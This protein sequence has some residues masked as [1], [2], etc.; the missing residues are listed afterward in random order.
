MKNFLLL[1]G[2]LYT[3]LTFGQQGAADSDFDT[4]G[5][6]TLD[7]AYTTTGAA[8]AVQPDGKILTAGTSFDDNGRPNA[9][10]MR[11]LPDGSRD[12]SF[13]NY[14]F[15][16]DSIYAIYPAV[17]AMVLQP[18]GS[19]I[20][21]GQG[22]GE[23][24]VAH[25]SSSGVGL[26][27]GNLGG[28]AQTIFGDGSY[29]AAVALQPDGRII[30]AGQAKQNNARNFVVVRYF[31]DGL[32]DTTFSYDGKVVTDF[33]GADDGANAVVC[34]SDGKIIAAGHANN[35][36]ALVR[37]NPDGI[38]DNS[39]GTNG[40]V[41]QTIGTTSVIKAMVLQPNGQ[42]LVAGYSVNGDQSS[43][44][45]R[46][47]T[48][49]ALDNTFGTN[50]I[51][52][53][54]SGYFTS[55]ALQPDG[56]IVAVGSPT[57][58]QAFAVMRLLQ[59]GAFDPDF[60]Q[61]GQALY[62]V[63]GQANATALQA[64]GKIIVAGSFGNTLAVARYISSFSVGTIHPKHAISERLIYPNPVTAN[65]TFGFELE[66]PAELTISVLNSQGQLLQQPVSAIT[67]QSGKQEIPLTLGQLI[68]GTYQLVLQAG[69][70][71]VTT[72][73]VKN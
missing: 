60:G 16:I 17:N 30:A 38:L 19:I 59:N 49:G 15:T 41:V 13:G 73:F 22:Y 43:I 71:L 46:Y 4:D 12:L 70:H 55:I 11:L 44:I 24:V 21:A 2:I 10:L 3:T 23:P 51:F 68:P 35:N 5:L 61:A 64:D 37:Y 47:N 66:S 50:G 58:I 72:Q 34:Q 29:F 63:F 62:W 53:W 31:P 48:N 45:A 25:F 39:F 26:P 42:I 32:L 9:L 56:K 69:G 7:L 1:C 54:P 57:G 67:F 33:F 28:I 65:A 18:N 6:V 36:F 20:V 27:F 14:G 40:K 8:V 52:K